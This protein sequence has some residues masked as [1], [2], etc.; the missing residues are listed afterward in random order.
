MIVP[1]QQN[2]KVHFA[3]VENLEQLI[4]AR[5][6]KVRYMLFTAFYL[7]AP[8]LLNIKTMWKSKVSPISVPSLIQS[9]CRHAI[10]DSGLFTLMFGS[11]KG[12]KDQKFL[13]RWT[14]GLIDLV[15]KSG[16]TGPMV[17]VDCQKV[18]GVDRAWYYRK[19]L[20]SNLPNRIIHVLHLEDGQSGLD[21]LIDYS[22]YLAISVPELRFAKKK[23]NVV[24]L[25]HYIKNKKPEIDL[26]LLGC[27]EQNLL[28]KLKFATS[29][30][31][32]SWTSPVRYGGIE[33]DKGKF[34]M[35]KLW[36]TSLHSEIWQKCCDEVQSMN[37]SAEIKLNPK[38]CP[39]LALQAE[40]LKARY[41]AQVG[42]QE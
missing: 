22:D 32:S 42:S 39:P 1:D 26:H 24:R 23:H 38:I 10:M 8:S 11:M 29:S 40:L 27:T 12:Q 25:A 21:R 28:S 17:E 14:Y 20:K 3:S 7:M 41:T 15:Q 35:N 37:L 30:D 2:L 6:A 31:S 34:H 4:A 16:Y 36:N 5:V 19:L 13:D 18:L 9:S 33:S